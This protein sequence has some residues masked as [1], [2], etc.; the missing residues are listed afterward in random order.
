M[1]NERVGTLAL[2]EEHGLRRVWE[3]HDRRLQVDICVTEHDRGRAS[4]MGMWV[5]RGLLPAHVDRTL[6]VSTYYTDDA[7][8]CW[9]MFNPTERPGGHGHVVDFDWV[10]EAT[11]DNERRLLEEIDRRYREFL[12]AESASE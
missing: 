12:D 5:R 1:A 7:G 10:L 11:P 9:G 6:S 2:I 3:S 8:R 4:L